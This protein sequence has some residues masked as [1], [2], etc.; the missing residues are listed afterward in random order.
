MTLVKT[1]QSLRAF[2]S[3]RA[4][5]RPL[6][7]KH[8]G[9]AAAW[10]S[11]LAHIAGAFG[12]NLIDLPACIYV[13]VSTFNPPQSMIHRAFAKEPIQC[14]LLGVPPDRTWDD[15]ISCF[16]YENKAMAVAASEQRLAVGLSNGTVMLYDSTTLHLVGTLTHG[17]PIRDLAFGP[18]TGSLVTTST[19]KVSLWNSDG[20]FQWATKFSNSQSPLS[21]AFSVDEEELL[22][23]VKD[24]ELHVISVEGGSNLDEIPLASD[25]E[26]ESDEDDG[27]RKYLLGTPPALVRVSP[28]HGLAAVTYRSAPVIIWDVERRQKAGVFYRPGTKGNYLH[29]QVQD[30][31]FNP[32]ADANLLAVA[33]DDIGVALCDPWTQE[34]HTLLKIEARTLASSP[35]GRTLVI[36]DRTGIIHMLSFE[37]S[38]RVLY[39][40]ASLNPMLQSL[41]FSPDSL[42]VFEARDNFCNAWEQPAL[43]RR[44]TF[45]D[46]SSESL[47]T[48]TGTASSVPEMVARPINHGD[49][50]TCLATA[51]V[52][53][54]EN[55]V[56]FCG[57]RD[58][59]ISA[60]DAA[61]GTLLNRLRAHPGGA[62]GY[63]ITVLVWHAGRSVLVAVNDIN[64][65]V[66]VRVAATTTEQ[67][68]V[69]YVAEPP[70]LFTRLAVR[71][72]VVHAS[73]ELF[74][75]STLEGDEV[76]TAAGE[77]VGRYDRERTELE[78]KRRWIQHPADDD[79][80]LMFQDQQVH[81]FR[82][83]DLAQLTP[84]TGLSL[85]L[86]SEA[87]AATASPPG[88]WSSRRGSDL[89][90]RTRRS[91]KDRTCF[92]VLDISELDPAAAEDAVPVT[93]CAKGLL[94]HVKAVIGQNKSLL[95]FV[96]VKGWVSSVSLK[97]LHRAGEYTRHFFIPRG[98]MVGETL[99]LR[100][101][102]RGHGVA[103]AYRDDLLVFQGFLAL[104]E[105]IAFST[106]GALAR[107]FTESWG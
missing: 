58:G 83:A 70:P 41:A 48:G 38:P 18:A 39:R 47:S 6:I 81:V 74:H 95:Y 33:Y 71:R 93:C 76:W 56:V 34:H 68:A 102:G 88:E 53:D 3:R 57:H 12:S 29:S 37:A 21:V 99:L 94:A 50:V 17:E 72:V 35:D 51:A 4:K 100:L 13:M 28:V 69:R 44:E 43:V 25:N 97:D 73:G 54:G 15:R 61:Q 96:D 20:E 9:P 52:D 42:R 64:S 30:M 86:S 7:D 75:L 23:P 24:G 22:V 27:G 26:S 92:E 10:V 11:D 32:L 8:S 31:A 78:E 79:L 40:I 2:L 104:E 106:E 19:R 59:M 62:D 60:H 87:C 36:G 45:D 66:A 46:N 65:C 80:L 55:S 82:W 91:D 85:A 16:V 77:M 101:V 5:H 67:G 84:P 103:M 49:H 14:K 63:A 1:V 90:V 98:W 89:F 107:R 105:K